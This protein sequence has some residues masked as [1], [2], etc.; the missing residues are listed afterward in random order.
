MLNDPQLV[1]EHQDSRQ[2]VQDKPIKWRIKELS[3]NFAPGRYCGWQIKE[4]Q[5]A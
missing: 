4:E 3:E 5:N 2:S 1:R